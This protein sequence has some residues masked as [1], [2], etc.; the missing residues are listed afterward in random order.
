ML[1]SW[2]FKKVNKVD[3]DKGNDASEACRRSA[4]RGVAP[5]NF[6]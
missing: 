2:K 6:K 5:A 3:L 4:R 1:R